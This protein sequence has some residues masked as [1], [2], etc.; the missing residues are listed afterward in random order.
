VSL[1]D[2]AE[3]M[4]RSMTGYGDAT[5][6]DSRFVLALEVKSVNHRF[7]KISS[8]IAEEVSYLQNDLEEL[9][10][11]RL[12]RGSIF[13]TLW[14]EPTSY[15][16]LYDIDESLLKKYW[17][18]L[19]KLKDELNTGE[20][21]YIKDLLLL[22]GVIHTEEALILGKEEVLPEAL[23]AMDEA[24]SKLL[25]MRE[26][27]G[28]NLEADMSLHARHLGN[29]L[30]KI[31]QAAP[32]ALEEYHQKL[33]QRV[34]L[35][36]GE[37]HGILAPEDI[38]KEVAILAERSDITEEIARMESHLKQFSDALESQEPVGRK[39]EFIVQEMFRESNTMGAKTSS[40]ELNQ[41]I[42]E[43][44]AEVDRLKEQ[45]LNIE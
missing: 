37:Q 18:T 23:R 32:L 14:F 20:E 24:L 11:K 27:E 7:L 39:L 10:R 33:D 45:V 29:L 13:F 28:R 17:T 43:L 19:R 21:I 36:L 1:E 12:V 15:S 40:R 42:V 8:K 6:E 9:I 35:L 2:E 31:K 4:L 26:E 38:L 16:D 34:R 3:A 25:S 41:H 22:P 5:V 44:K 30:E